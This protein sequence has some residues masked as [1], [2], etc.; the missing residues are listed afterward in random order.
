M[1]KMYGDVLPSPEHARVALSMLDAA[2]VSTVDA[3]ALSLLQE[4]L[5]DASS[6]SA[7][8]P[9]PSSTGQSFRAATHPPSTRPRPG[10]RLKPSASR[11]ACCSRR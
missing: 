4:F 1:K 7:T 10:C 2:P 8:E 5:L 3:F 11:R 9:V 6:D